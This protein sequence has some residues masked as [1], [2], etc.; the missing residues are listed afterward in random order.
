[1]PYIITHCWYPLNKADEVAKR[2]LEVLEK[3]PPDESLAK[4]VVPA[5][6]SS[7][8]E[9]LETL[10]IVDV[11]RQKLGDALERDTRFM[12]EF[13][14]I[15]GFNYEIKIWSKVEEALERIGLGG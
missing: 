6:V 11:E 7:N 14:S 12:I 3:Y 10:A 8:Q 13:R 5:S 1:M 2:Y 4:Q 9:G 15:E